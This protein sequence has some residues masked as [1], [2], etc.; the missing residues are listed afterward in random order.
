MSVFDSLCHSFGTVS[1][2]GY[3]PWNASIGVSPSDASIKAWQKIVWKFAILRAQSR[4]SWFETVDF[5]R[6]L[7]PQITALNISFNLSRCLARRRFDFDL[8]KISKVMKSRDRTFNAEC[9][10]SDLLNSYL[11]AGGELETGTKV[12]RLEKGLVH[13]ANGAHR[14]RYVIVA[15]GRQ[16]PDVSGMPVRIVKSPILVV[17]PALTD[18]N[19]IRMTPNMNDTFNHLYHSVE[20][21][22][23]SLIGN[24]RFYAAADAVDEEAL[25]AELLKEVGNIFGGTIESDQAS[26]YF[27]YKT[28]A[29][30]TRGLRNYQYQII[31]E[32]NS[33]V[34]L[35]GKM[36]LAFSLAVNLCRHFGIDPA[37]EIGPLKEDAA[38]DA[39]ATPEHYTRFT[40]L[41]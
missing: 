25:K 11:S 39:I 22:D 18:V 13:T 28:E 7:S 23:Y 41:A 1:T 12:E 10:F 3:S 24:A 34:I 21:G 4:L 5:T 19:F 33:V 16:I 26:L 35:P 8:G 29:K 32:G 38:M 9:L 40:E 31:E 30:S 2:S 6:E 36:T 27:G 14:S 20:G 15:A 37:T 17:K